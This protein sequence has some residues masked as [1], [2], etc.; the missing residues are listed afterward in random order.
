MMATLGNGRQ[1]CIILEDESFSKNFTLGKGRPQGDPPSPIQYN[2]AEQILLF[3][4]EL[5]GQIMSVI[6]Q[7]PVIPPDEIGREMNCE[8][9]S[10][11]AFADDTTVLTLATFENLQSLKQFLTDFG[12]ISGLFCNIEKSYI[13]R[14]G[15]RQEFNNDIVNLGF[16]EADSIC[17]LGLNI[18]F[19]L[20][21][22][23]NYH[24]KT[25]QKVTNIANFW[26]RFFLSLPGRINIAKTLIL[27]QISYIGCIIKPTQQQ[28]RA[29]S[30]IYENFVKGNLNISRANLYLPINKGGVGLIDISNFL[31]A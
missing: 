12:E 9:S 19:N 28:L 17:I 24:N 18:D 6:P 25:I 10:A 29:L 15:N 7:N 1:A 21:Y 2:L 5:S 26:R 16:T 31:T 14:I 13:M 22:L 23:N 4:I 3:K 27:S 8:T 30:D 20:D 11:D